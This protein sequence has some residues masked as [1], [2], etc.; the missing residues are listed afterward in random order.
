MSKIPTLTAPLGLAL[1]LTGCGNVGGGET[2]VH[3]NDNTIV[4]D[5]AIDRVAAA[6]AEFDSTP[7]VTDADIR[8]VYETVRGRALEGDLDAALVLLK[9]A[10]IQR[11]PPDS[12]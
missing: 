2:V 6:L 5:R 12:D 10:A 11:T 1:L 9:V 8:A 4:Q 3:G 7:E